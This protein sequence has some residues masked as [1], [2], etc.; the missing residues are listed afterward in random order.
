MQSSKFIEDVAFHATLIEASLKQER[1]IWFIW[2]DKPRLII[3]LKQRKKA[4]KLNW[5]SVCLFWK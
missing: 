3:F 4:L 2:S 1:A 5:K